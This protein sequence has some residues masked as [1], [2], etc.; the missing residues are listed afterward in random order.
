MKK[1]TP[2]DGL[3]RLLMT[4]ATGDVMRAIGLTNIDLWT[5]T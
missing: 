4:V 5:S 2:L 3:D 1:A